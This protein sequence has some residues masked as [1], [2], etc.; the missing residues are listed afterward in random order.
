[1][2]TF[3]GWEVNLFGLIIFSTPGKLFLYGKPGFSGT[4]LST[5]NR[6]NREVTGCRDFTRD[7]PRYPEENIAGYL[8]SSR[9]THKNWI[10]LVVYHILPHNL[11]HT[12]ML[13][14]DAKK[15]VSK[16][17]ISHT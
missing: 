5:E 2:N 16:G 7:D 15:R 10:E 6:M 13:R 9:L 3:R 4:K 14:S 17:N 11:T 1:M 8:G 12:N